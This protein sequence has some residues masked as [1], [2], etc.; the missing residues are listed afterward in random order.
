[1]RSGA[2]RGD[3]VKA[4]GDVELVA[5]VDGGR[6]LLAFAP[7]GELHVVETATGRP[8]RQPFRLP[9]G[10]GVAVF[11]R[12]GARL[13]IADTSNVVSQWDTAT[14]RP[15]GS[16]MAQPSRV[17][18][19]HYSPNG[20][21]LAVL[22]ED[23]AVRLWDVRTGLPLGPPLLHASQVVAVSFS[24]DGSAVLTA[25][26]TGRTHTWPLAVPVADDRQRLVMWLRVM[27]GA[28]LAR[29]EIEPLGVATWRHER[30]QLARRWPA[31]DPALALPG[32]GAWHAARAGDAEDAGNTTAALRHLDRLIALGPPNWSSY[33]R[34]G[35]AFS[36]AGALDWAAEAYDRA[37]ALDLR[38]TRDWYRQQAAIS[39]ALDRQEAALWYDTRL[40]RAGDD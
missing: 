2:P 18:S 30:E 11:S 10:V 31:P 35:R 4:G 26:E 6:T 5:F 1:V 19:L 40:A 34:K 15:C 39:R 33:A 12:D 7:V 24:P 16:R 23:E 17:V 8:R 28:R 37:E 13:A 36:Q 25:T 9:A 14:G 29:G 3:F 20:L 32:D 21:T 22:C 27:S 38:R